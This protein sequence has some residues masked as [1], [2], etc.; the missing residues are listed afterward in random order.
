MYEIAVQVKSC[1]DK[2][3]QLF[4]Q[5]DQNSAIATLFLEYI[6]F[7]NDYK[8]YRLVIKSIDTRLSSLFDTRDYSHLIHVQLL[9]YKTEALWNLRESVKHYT[10]SYIQPHMLIMLFNLGK[11]IVSRF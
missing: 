4:G 11:R 1:R 8:L 6:Q 9:Q 10:C 7:L 5:E 2:L 3:N